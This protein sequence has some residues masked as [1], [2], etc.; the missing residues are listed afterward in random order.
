[1]A[2]SEHLLKDR[3]E[4][5]LST[6][7]SAKDTPDGR[8]PQCIA[9]RGYKAAFPE[10]TMGA[11]KGAVEV[12]AH[13]IETDLHLS[14]D[15]VVLLSHDPTLKRCFGKDEKL[16]D[17]DWEYIKTL[18]TLKGD[19]PM[20]R[21]KDLLEYLAPPDL[22]DIWLLL[23]IKVPVPPT[24]KEAMFGD[25]AKQ[26]KL[27][28]YVNE[29]FKAIAAT[30]ADVK[31]SS[32]PWSERVVVGCWAAKYLPLCPKY[33]PEY[34]I[35]HIGFSISY[36]RQFLKIPNLSYNMFLMLLVGPRGNALLR[37]LKKSRSSSTF[38]W[39]VNEESWMKWGIRK[40]VDGVITDD[41]KKYLEVCKSY[42]KSEWLWHSWASWKAII[43]MHLRALTW[44]FAFR[45]K[46]GYFVDVQKVRKSL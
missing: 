13:A 35:T 29:L 14:K 44:G 18:R 37:D 4:I 27:D 10:N 36:A 34:P 31:P 39:T 45:Y 12:G 11:F 23:D 28:D 38:L 24:L 42:N 46:H 3:M 2:E 19:Q 25:K 20:P 30:L 21:L 40:D 6:F 41:P 33:L 7:T 1:M 16:I 8:R 32:R 26:A 15:G 22:E 9:H 43:K 17:C 5:P